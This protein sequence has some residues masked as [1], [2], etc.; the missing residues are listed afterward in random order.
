MSLDEDKEI[1]LISESYRDERLPKDIGFFTVKSVA[2]VGETYRNP[3]AK[4]Y[5]LTG[6]TSP[7][8]AQFDR[9]DVVKPP[10]SMNDTYAEER[11]NLAEE[12]VSRFVRDVGFEP[13]QVVIMRATNPTPAREVL[14]V[15][16]IDE[17]FRPGDNGDRATFVDPALSGDFVYTKNPEVVLGCRPGDCPIVLLQGISNDR[18]PIIGM[19]HGGWQNL[20]AGQLEQAV[21]FM[22]EQGIAPAE[23]SVYV[24]SGAAKESFPYTQTARPG[25]P[26]GRFTSPN[27]DDLARDVHYDET[28][29]KY[30]FNIDMFGYIDKALTRKGV[31]NIIHDGSDTA[32]PS[33]GYSSHSRAVNHLAGAVE[34]RDLVLASLKYPLPR[35]S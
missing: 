14:N 20:N 18:Q 2:S 6:N 5:E 35:N 32:D 27:V 12:R 30:H 22:A 13:S 16:N 8:Y 17:V 15:V 19:F 31:E 34:T 1:K 33:S 7:A 24:G 29:Q 9:P 21:D 4:R 25:S 28:D 11:A 23:L 26:E 10:L 3:A